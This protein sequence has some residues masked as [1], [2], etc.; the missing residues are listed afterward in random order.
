MNWFI[1]L[2]RTAPGLCH[3]SVCLSLQALPHRHTGALS[4]LLLWV[5]VV[6]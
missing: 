4:F 6:W 1:V 2:Q 5:E 3:K